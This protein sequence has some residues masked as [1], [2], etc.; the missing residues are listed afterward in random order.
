[1]DF[2][3]DISHVSNRIDNNRF[4][5]QFEKLKDMKNYSISSIV[6]FFICSTILYSQDK[7]QVRLEGALRFNYNNSSWKEAQKKRGGDISYDMFAISPKVA[8]KG[9]ILDIKYRIYEDQSGGGMLRQGFI[10]YDLNEKNQLQF[11]LTRVPFGI[12]PY[13]SHSYFLGMGYYLGLEDDYDVGLKYKREGEKFDYQLAFFKNSDLASEIGGDGVESMR[14]Y[15]Y[16]VGGRNRETNQFNGKLVYKTEGEFKHR[17]GAS[18][19]YGGLYNVDTKEMGD[20]FALA[21]HYELDYK[22]FNL[23]TQVSRFEK[24]PKNIEGESRDIVELIAYNAAYEVAA[25]GTLYTVGASY[26][27]PINRK[28]LSQ[29][30]VY[31]DFAYLDKDK[32][33]FESSI[34]NK[35]GIRLQSGGIYTYVEYVAAKNQPWFGPEWTKAFSEGDPNHDWEGRFNINVGYYF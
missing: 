29:I 5:G 19:M 10:G 35:L 7:P 15:S 3:N 31:N 16:D 25:K 9:F 23:K 2:I 1:M 26:D 28:A 24:N 34:T 21:G 30:Q 27:F 8:Y 33:E 17:I 11:G 6:V 14:R 12:E 18:F 13:N 4:V 32:S 22:R 20:H